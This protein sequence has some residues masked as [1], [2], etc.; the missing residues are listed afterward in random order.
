MNKPR[1]ISLTKQDSGRS[2]D[3]GIDVLTPKTPISKVIVNPAGLFSPGVQSNAILSPEI[4]QRLSAQP[5]Q[6]F[7]T[8]HSLDR[9]RQTCIEQTPGY[10]LMPNKVNRP[11]D[12]AQS[13][14]PREPG[15]R[16]DASSSRHYPSWMSV[17][18]HHAINKPVDVGLL[19]HA[20]SHNR[21]ETPVQDIFVQQEAPSSVAG[22][23]MEKSR[24]NA[25]EDDSHYGKQTRA[26]G[27]GNLNSEQVGLHQA[28]QLGLGQE[29][30][31]MDI[32][33]E[34]K[35]LCFIV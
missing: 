24:I 30:E 8:K 9:E 11:L 15:P 26:L 16:D 3:S 6:S 12:R 18:G 10:S 23:K 1:T 17:E 20:K 31:K 35:Y 19:A 28:G 27:A 34:S 21:P 25:G 33:C 4:Q 29:D 5:E 2:E 14:P 7:L 13:F 22:I 32:P